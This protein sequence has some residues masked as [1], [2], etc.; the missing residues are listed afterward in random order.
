MKKF[1]KFYL[2]AIST[3]EKG[4]PIRS[5][6][7]YAYLFPRLHVD[8]QMASTALY[9]LEL[10]AKYLD[11]CFGGNSLDEHPALKIIAELVS[12]LEVS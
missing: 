6:P 2:Q 3:F 8:E 7:L 5:I 11:N 1:L 9:R 12:K 4:L 10:E